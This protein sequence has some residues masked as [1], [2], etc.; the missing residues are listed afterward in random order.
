MVRKLGNLKTP[1]SEKLVSSMNNHI[2]ERRIK[3]TAV[4]LYLK[5]PNIYQDYLEQWK[6]NETFQLPSKYLIRK[7]I[8]NIITRLY[9]KEANQA[10]INTTVLNEDDLPLSMIAEDLSLRA[11][12]AQ[13][14]TSLQEELEETLRAS[15]TE[16]PFKPVSTSLDRLESVIKKEMDLFECGGTKGRFLQFA[17]NSLI[18]LPISVESE[19]AFSAAGYIATDIRCRLAD[20]TLNTL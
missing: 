7:E 16:S 4:L 12:A 13:N 19:R 10:E 18:T 2:S 9:R 3:A 14:Y 1:L 11:I 15:K 8:K 6:G 20:N 5:N 17:Y